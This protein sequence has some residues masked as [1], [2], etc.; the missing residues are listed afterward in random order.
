[1]LCDCPGL[2]LPSFVTTKA[3]LVVSGIL[4]KDQMRDYI[5]PSQ[6]VYLGRIVIAIAN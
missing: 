3:D 6:L 4:P 2:V 5:P 1:M